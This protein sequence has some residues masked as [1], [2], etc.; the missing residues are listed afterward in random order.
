MK[1]I[2]L[3][4]D[5]PIMLPP[6]DTDDREAAIQSFLKKLVEAFQTV[7]MGLT[8]LPYSDIA[9]F[10]NSFS[11]WSK[12]VDMSGL[13]ENPFTS[14]KLSRTYFDL[15]SLFD[16]QKWWWYKIQWEISTLYWSRDLMLFDDV[17]FSWN[18][19]KAIIDQCSIWVKE[20]FALYSAKKD[21]SWIQI[22][23]LLSWQRFN[24][25]FDWR[26][27]LWIAKWWWASLENWSWVP[28]LYQGLL[29]KYLWLDVKDTITK[30]FLEAINSANYDLYNALWLINTKLSDFSRFAWL[31]T[32]KP[33]MTIGDLCNN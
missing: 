4:D 16:A 24:N 32:W 23:S 19:L 17:V 5:L 22:T 26:D 11:E 29:A 9:K 18:T 13:V 21:I 20:V 28:F 12:V 15:G 10:I 7:N 30:L 6:S 27:L 31:N 3:V 8:V 2:L 14:I 1:D 25:V 33:Q